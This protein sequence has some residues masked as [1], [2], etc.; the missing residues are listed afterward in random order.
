[1]KPPPSLLVVLLA[2]LKNYFSKRF[3]PKSGRAD[4]A[5]Y[6]DLLEYKINIDHRGWQHQIHT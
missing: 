3:K 6:M 2:S 4:H 5:F 1:M